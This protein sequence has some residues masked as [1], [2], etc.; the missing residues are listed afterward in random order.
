M[1]EPFDYEVAIEI[2][3]QGK[4]PL[5]NALDKEYD[6]SEPNETYIR[7]LENKKAAI[8]QLMSELD[9]KDE[10]LIKMILDLEARYIFK[11]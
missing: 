4:A 2:L 8:D 11:G 3:G 7:F 1:L 5:V 9:S 10:Y 6:K